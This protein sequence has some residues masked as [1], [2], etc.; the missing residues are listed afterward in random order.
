MSKILNT[1]NKINLYQG[2]VSILWILSVIGFFVLDP[3]SRSQ[4]YATLYMIFIGPILIFL[5]S[6]LDVLKHCSWCNRRNIVFKDG[7]CSV[8]YEHVN[9]DGS[10]NRRRSSNKQYQFYVSKYECSD[11]GAV[12]E[13][14]SKYSDNPN[15]YSKTV[16]RYLLS[17]GEG[18]R[19]GID[20]HNVIKS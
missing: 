18:E 19:A 3:T 17:P 9:K 8:T 10:R 13:Y 15:Q 4:A 7:C 11:C 2:I 14:V 6:L 12:S 5:G 20:L 16:S 1:S